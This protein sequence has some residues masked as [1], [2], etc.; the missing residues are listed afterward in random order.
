MKILHCEYQEN[1][2]PIHGR[3]NTPPPPIFCQ[4]KIKS[5]K[6]VTYE[7]KEVD[8]SFHCKKCGECCEIRYS[9]T[10]YIQGMICVVEWKRSL[11][12]LKSFKIGFIGLPS[13]IPFF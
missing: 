12:A 1:S 9:T 3:R 11:C 13:N 5:L 4:P 8:I 6:I 7:Y 10:I 2:R